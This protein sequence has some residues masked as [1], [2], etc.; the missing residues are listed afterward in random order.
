M[1]RDKWK[2]P[3]L[4]I[5]YVNGPLNA[6]TQLTIRKHVYQTPLESIFFFIKTDVNFEMCLFNM[7]YL[8]VKF[9]ERKQDYESML[10]TIFRNSIKKIRTQR[11]ILQNIKKSNWKNIGKIENIAVIKKNI[12]NLNKCYKFLK[13]R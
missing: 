1:W 8:W 11:N 5:N 3:A 13:R 2:N 7:L 4:L 10:A 12:Y 9:S 6:A